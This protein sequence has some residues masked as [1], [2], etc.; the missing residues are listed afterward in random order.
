MKQL[1][2]FIRHLLG[3]RTQNEDYIAGYRYAVE[4]I[5]NDRYIPTCPPEF[6]TA[7]DD[8]VDQAIID[9]AKSDYYG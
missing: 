3:I 8:G 6:R 4:E 7:F 1:L 2:E 5:Q 9:Y